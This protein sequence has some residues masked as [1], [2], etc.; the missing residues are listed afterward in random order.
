MEYLLLSDPTARILLAVALA[1]VLGALLGLEREV[2]GKPAGLRTNMLVAGAAALLVGLSEVLVRRFHDEI[3]ARIIRSD[4]IRIIQAIIIG[5]SFL[6]AGTII[7][8]E[9]KRHIEGLTTAASL[10]F[11]TA[12]GICAAL[13]EELL[14]ILLT[15]VVVAV[16]KLLGLVERRSFGGE[17]EDEDEQGV[18]R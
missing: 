15:V 14:A 6:G 17:A 9:S 16:L 5:V 12:V 7:R 4:P 18:P 3:G 10:L 11:A 13:S 1:M 8:H 2:A